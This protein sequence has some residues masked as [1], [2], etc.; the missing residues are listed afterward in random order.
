MRIETDG[1]GFFGDFSVQGAT[2]SQRP[3]ED[4]PTVSIT[5]KAVLGHVVVKVSAQ[6]GR[7]RQAIDSLLGW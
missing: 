4:A 3:P 5:G 1:I 2:K 6:R 7:L